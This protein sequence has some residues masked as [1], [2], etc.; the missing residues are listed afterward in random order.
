MRIITE[1]RE[2]IEFIEKKYALVSI[3]EVEEVTEV[4]RCRAKERTYDAI[5]PRP[6]ER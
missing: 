2:R 1:L 4:A 3:G 5:Y 6:N